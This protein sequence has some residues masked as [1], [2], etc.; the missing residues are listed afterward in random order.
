MRRLLAVLLLLA[1]ACAGA[2]AYLHTEAAEVRDMYTVFLNGSTNQSG[3]HRFLYGPQCGANLTVI[4]ENVSV[5]TTDYT[6]YNLTIHGTPLYPGKT[7]CYAAWN[8]TYL[9]NEVS[10]TMDSAQ[11]VAVPTYQTAYSDP[12]LATDWNFSKMANVVPTAYTSV[13]GT[14][15][16]PILWLSV[17]GAIW[18]R[19][20]S[21]RIPALLF[22]FLAVFI[23]PYMP[24]DVQRLMYVIMAIVLVGFVVLIFR[25]V[26]GRG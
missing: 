8:G 11:T 21:A 17:L 22:F 13:W 19:V 6:F 20:E 7:Y 24:S 4:T 2:N 12:F 16:W 25:K 5:T 26:R 1:L 3:N 23:M 9:A 18:L 15:L 14:W 10:F